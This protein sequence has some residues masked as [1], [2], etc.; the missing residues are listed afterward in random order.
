MTPAPG[1][2]RRTLLDAVH[3]IIAARNNGT[4]ALEGGCV[5]QSKKDGKRCIIGALFSDAQLAYIHHFKLNGATISS[6]KGWVGAANIEFVTGL[7]LDQAAALQSEWDSG[8]Q[9]RAVNAISNLNMGLKSVTIKGVEF[10][11]YD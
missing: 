7:T 5:Y 3:A 11:P 4:L 1:F 2:T 10:R 8:H 6:L 9:Q